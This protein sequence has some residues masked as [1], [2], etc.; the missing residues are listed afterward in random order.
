MY[1]V[2]VMAVV[3]VVVVCGR[4][5]VV[6][7]AGVVCVLRVATR[8]GA[9]VL[10]VARLKAIGGCMV[11]QELMVGWHVAKHTGGL[12]C[13]HVPLA[14]VGIPA[15]LQQVDHNDTSPV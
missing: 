5:V 4:A 15:P 1:G 6:V 8:P 2:L 12:R 9:I 13:Y 11:C 10:L 3:V 14:V 7:Y